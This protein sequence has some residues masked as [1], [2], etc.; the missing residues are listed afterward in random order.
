[1]KSKKQRNKEKILRE[2]KES[3]LEV[4]KAF[5]EGRQL[6]TLEDFLKELES[7]K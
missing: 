3:I 6:Q 1:M 2:L 5:K 4:R 7:E